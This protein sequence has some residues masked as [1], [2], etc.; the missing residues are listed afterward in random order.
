MT[1]TTGSSRP[2]R[3]ASELIELVEVVTSTKPPNGFPLSCTP[4]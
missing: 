2:Y 1:V 3:W 4:E